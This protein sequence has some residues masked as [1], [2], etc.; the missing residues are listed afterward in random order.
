MRRLW[1][2]LAGWTLVEIICF[3][4][5]GRAVVGVD[6][7]GPD[8]QVDILIGF[9]FC[10]V[11][12]FLYVIRSRILAGIFAA[13]GLLGM[14]WSTLWQPFDGALLTVLLIW[15]LGR[16]PGW[17]ERENVSGKIYPDPTRYSAV[18]WA[19]SVRLVGRIALWCLGGWVLWEFNSVFPSGRSEIT[20]AA[21]LTA[22]VVSLIALSVGM[23]SAILIHF[24]VK[25]RFSR[26]LD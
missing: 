7:F 24:M 9:V 11:P 5:L 20:P 17:R 3:Y 21:G 25:Y 13:G 4:P 2:A 22:S 23:L 26:F 15:L 12:V 18:A 19:R 6:V 10:G 8:Q 14:T 1:C 16:K